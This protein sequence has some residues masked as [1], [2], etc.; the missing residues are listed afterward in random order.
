MWTVG[1]AERRERFDAILM[2]TRD[3][4]IGYFESAREVGRILRDHAGEDWTP[5][6]VRS[7]VCFVLVAGGRN[8]TRWRCWLVEVA[9]A[10]LSLQSGRPW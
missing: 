8:P 4:E 2:A 1:L 10:V 3:R 6:E 9:M 7:A 5:P